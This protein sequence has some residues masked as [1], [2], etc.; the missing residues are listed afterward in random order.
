[1]NELEDVQGETRNPQAPCADTLLE[2][3]RGDAQPSPT[4]LP[5]LAFSVRETALML[6]VCEKTVRRLLDRGLLKASRAL[7][8]KLIHRNEIE[9]FLRDTSE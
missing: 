5:R 1:M 4:G 2:H 8:H 7:R 3:F 6:G 9:R